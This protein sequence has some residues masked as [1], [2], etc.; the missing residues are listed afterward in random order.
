MENWLEEG[1]T[2]ARALPTYERRPEQLAMAEAVAACIESGGVLLVEAGTGTGKTLAYLAPVVA[3]GSRVVVSTGTKTLQ[4]QI[5]EKDVP[6]LQAHSPIPFRAAVLKG[7]G[8]YVCLLR[9]RARQH[10]AGLFDPDE[11]LLRRV[12]RW[13]ETTH[14]GDRAGLAD[15]PENH[16][17]WSDVVSTS[18]TC[19]GSGCAHYDEC[20]VMRARRRALA[21]DVVVVNHHLFFADLAVKDQWEA[22]LLPQPDVVVFDEAHQL[23]DVA[24]A[25][26]GATVSSVLLNAVARDVE[27]ALPGVGDDKTLR[28]AVARL[29]ESSNRL[30]G[31][32]AE[33]GEGRTRLTRALLPEG[34]EEDWFALD[35]GL[36]HLSA[37]VERLAEKDE[38]LLAHVRRIG[39][40]RERLGRVLEVEKPGHVHWVERRPRW[41]ALQTSPIDAAPILRERL[42]G[43]RRS[44]VFTSATLATAGDFSFFRERLGIGAEAVELALPAGFDYPRQVLLYVPD[45]LPDPREP[46]FVDA[47]ADEVVRLLAASRGRAFVLF[48]SHANLRACH[49]RVA[50]RVPWSLLVQGERPRDALLQEFREDTHSVLFATASFW[51]GVDVAGEAL[52]CVIIDKL[53]FGH[54]DEPLLQARLE[55]VKER[56][57]EPFRDFQVPSAVIA[58]RQGFGR[59]VRTRTDRGIVA[60]LDRRLHTKAYGR[61]FLAA[62]PECER[63]TEFAR[64]QRWAEE[65]LS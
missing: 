46:A 58:L 64:V 44:L 31:R 23:E 7:R 37:G 3:S 28:G 19:V 16:P 13:S 25:F 18:D 35:N 43:Q 38:T 55:A 47:V 54:P 26:F 30:F 1:G 10:A 57:G 32:F 53:P 59:L 49:A 8:N 45:S 4:Q 34:T 42:L 56:G 33:F 50:G 27:A 36:H 41:A 48:T 15:L 63:T 9:L 21:S 2:L 24:C 12:V 6:F 22:D 62:L 40:L 39:D 65:N 61:R 29:R 11:E 14:D 20:F 17:L 5:I 51:E 60:L 52:S